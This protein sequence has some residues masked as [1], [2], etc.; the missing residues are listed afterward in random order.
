MRFRDLFGNIRPVIGTVALPPLPGSPAYGGA[1]D[2]IRRRALHDARLLVES[3]C[4]AVLLDNLHDGPFGS[5]QAPPETVAA[6]SVLTAAVVD[7]LVVPVGLQVRRNDARAA[8]GIATVA[9]ARFVRVPVHVGTVKGEDGL[10][11]GRSPDTLRCRAA[12]GSDVAIFADVSARHAKPTGEA[13]PLRCAHETYFRGLADALVVTGRQK[14]APCDLEQ[15]KAVRGTL[16][17]A[18]LLGADGVTPA[19][20]PAILSVADGLILGEWCHADEDPAKPLEPERVA[21]LVQS[22]EQCV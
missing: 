6:L 17:D 20:I 19:T 4:D 11:E 13:D 2:P 14:G 9:E 7:A 18:P 15:A 8:V 16:H 1:F 5:D 3:G 10:V 21:K 12:L 22:V